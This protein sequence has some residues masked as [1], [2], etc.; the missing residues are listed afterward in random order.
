MPEH[1]DKT[2]VS[3]LQHLIKHCARE[4]QE[5]YD[6]LEE[7]INYY[8]GRHY[9]LAQIKDMQTTGTI[10][11]KYNLYREQTNMITGYT[12][13]VVNTI[14]ITGQQ[15]E[16]A[17]VASTLHDVVNY[18]FRQNQFDT[19]KGLD[20]VTNSILSGV[21]SVYCAPVDTGRVDEF[22]RPIYDLEIEPIPMQE[23]ILDP[24]SVKP[25]YSDAQ[26]ITR[27]VWVSKERVH[28]LFPDKTEII[29]SISPNQEQT[30]ISIQDKTFR[31]IGTYGTGSSYV[32]G[33]EMI[34]LLHTVIKDGEKTFSIYWAGDTVIDKSEITFK[35]TQF[36][37]VVYK[38]NNF[39]RIEF[40]GILRDLKEKQ[41]LVN[42]MYRRTQQ[43]LSNEKMIVE[44]DAVD[45]KNTL[46]R[47]MASDSPLLEVKRKDGV[48]FIN[49]TAD[50]RYHMELMDSTIRKA[51][52]AL[53]LNPSFYGQ[54][55][56]SDSGR[57]VELQQRSAI[58]AL[59]P[60]KKKIQQ[61]YR[62]LARQVSSLVQQYYTATQTIALV[63]DRL[64]RK[65]LTLNEPIKIYTNEYEQDE[66]GNLIIG[67]DGQ[68]V[69]K[70][71]YYFEEVLDPETGKVVVDDDGNE[72]RAP[73]PI[74]GTEIQF[75]D[76]D[77]V[78]DTTAYDDKDEK[79]REQVANL[80]AQAGQ[81][82]VQINPA[83][84]LNLVKIQLE[85]YKTE[86]SAELSA[87]LERIIQQVA[88]AQGGQ[89]AAS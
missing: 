75:F 24:Q 57:K 15:Q 32:E 51:H 56:A 89:N 80:L 22:G 1:A 9:D 50:L 48:E 11:I 42:R 74:R 66:A 59:E 44:P 18:I 45:D 83:E 36:P 86:Q 87:S 13:T 76:H 34:Q 23:L 73:L 65:W 19:S 10:P 54:S 2:S 3:Y 12:S 78:V 21:F 70:F 69:R 53:G 17:T 58:T 49:K 71:N 27:V 6:N 61:A 68:P 60:F 4:Y 20:A 79:L 47:Q 26:H 28:T 37:Y 52:D 88:Q 55:Y 72:V 29:D 16:D 43:L 85:G 62:T 14:R 77:I 63:D 38:V 84:Y 67:E 30:Q 31:S 40:Y 8:E 39:S 81:I 33:Q 5:S 7:S 35:K 64:G 46:A 25:D 82:I 41:D